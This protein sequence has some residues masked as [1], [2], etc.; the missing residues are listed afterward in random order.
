MKIS[1]IQKIIENF[2]PTA[3][4]EDYDNVGLVTGNSNLEVKG[5][6]ICVDVTEEIIEEALSKN[7]NLIISHHPVIFSGL[8]KLTGNHYSERIILKALK[9][10]IAIYSA[11]TNIDSVKN[12]VSFA[13]ARVIGLNQV[14]V[15]RPMKGILRKI[16]T[17][18]PGSHEQK[19]RE[20]LFEAGAGHLGDYDSCSYNIKGT[21]TFRGLEGT[22]PFLGEKGKLSLEE[23]TRIETIFPAYLSGKIVNAL[24]ESHPYEEVA[25]DI[26]P[27]ENVHVNAGMGAIGVLEAPVIDE[28]FLLHVKDKLKAGVIRHTRLT[29]K[30]VQKVAV[31]GGSG[32]SLLKDAI[33][34]EADLFL[35]G[36]I[37]YHQF[38]D[39]DNRVILADA[40]HYET[41]QFTK[42]IFFNMITKKMPNFAVYLSE[43]NSNPINYL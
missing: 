38:F 5:I 22:N 16:V 29:G 35:T 11:H 9:N 4:Q 13:L 33:A 28:D 31:C 39:A 21:G 7:C 40:G 19:V 3:L 14:Q 43:I 32:I 8:K 1:E 34:A 41:E 42:N 27:L 18:V 23:E 30:R 20:A 17:F 2:A 37:K 10:D 6:L 26:Y 36:D 24:L 25:Y 15:L 12:G